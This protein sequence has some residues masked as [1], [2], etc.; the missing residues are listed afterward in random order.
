MIESSRSD[1]DFTNIL[2]TTL[3]KGGDTDS[4]CAIVMCI[5][6]A[7]VGY[8]RIPSYFRNKL[9][10]MKMSESIRPRPE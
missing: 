2:I 10:N 9:I 3:N 4:C 5:V 7:I 1:I 6:G 8:D